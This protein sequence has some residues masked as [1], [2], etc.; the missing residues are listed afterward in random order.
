VK[1]GGDVRAHPW[2]YVKVRIRK[3]GVATMKPLRCARARFSLAMISRAARAGRIAPRCS[4]TTS[5]SAP[6]MRVQ[7]V[8]REGEGPAKL[9]G[10]AS[11]R[12]MRARGSRSRRCRP[13]TR[14]GCARRV[15]SR[16]RGHHR[17]GRRRSRTMRRVMRN[18]LK[19][20]NTVTPTGPQTSTTPERTAVRP[21]CK[22][23]PAWPTTTIRAGSRAA[24]SRLGNL[25]PRS[26]CG[27]GSGK[28]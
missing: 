4:A 19:T 13:S 26:G 9:D 12:C 24:Q 10:D 25:F 15:A 3:M 27:T 6:R 22:T 11:P 21:T 17:P 1:H 7:I 5:G 20:K 18:P 14:A 28:Q 16:R 23:F 2:R 8:R